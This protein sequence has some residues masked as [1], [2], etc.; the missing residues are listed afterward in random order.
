MIVDEIRMDLI[1]FCYFE[2]FV[3]FH[4]GNNDTNEIPRSIITL[5]D[6][7]IFNVYIWLA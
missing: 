1:G 7:R 4:A 6:Y 5:V 2:S 3:S